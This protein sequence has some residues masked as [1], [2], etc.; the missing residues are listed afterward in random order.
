MYL[1]VVMY[2]QAKMSPKNDCRSIR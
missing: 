1:Y 2:V